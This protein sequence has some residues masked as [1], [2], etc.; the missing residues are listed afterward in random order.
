MDS[1][2]RRE[3][4]ARWSKSTVMIGKRWWLLHLHAHTITIQS[5]VRDIGRVRTEMAN[6]EFDARLARWEAIRG[7]NYGLEDK[8]I[9]LRQGDSGRYRRYRS[10]TTEAYQPYDNPDR[11]TT[12]EMSVDDWIHGHDY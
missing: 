8:H 11:V 6:T 2:Q 3:I 9:P 5:L 7:R 4:Q 10:E 12:H 1:R